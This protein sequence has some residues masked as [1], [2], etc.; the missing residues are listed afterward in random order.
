MAALIS[1]YFAARAGLPLIPDAPRVRVVQ[2]Q[3]L[4]VALPWVMR[5]LHLPTP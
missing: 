4:G 5:A 1:G 3:Q 2:K